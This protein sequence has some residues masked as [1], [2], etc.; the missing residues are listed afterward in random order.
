M[1]DTLESTIAELK[2]D[3]AILEDNENRRREFISNI[4]HE[5]KTPIALI[6]GYAEGLQEGVMDD[7]DSRNMYL[8]VIIDE[9][10]RMNRLVKELLTLNQLER[11]EDTVLE[12]VDLNGL[13]RGVID[14]NTILFETNDIEVTYPDLS[15][16]LI[17]LADEF[18][19]EQVV[20][21]YISNAIHYSKA[22]DS[23]NKKR[24]DIKQTIKDDIV[25][26]SVFN[27]GD[28]I[29]DK[30]IDQIWDKFYKVDKARSREYGGS[31][32]GLSVVKAVMEKFKHKYGVI[33]HADGVEF[34]FELEINKQ[35]I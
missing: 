2:K 23:D 14:A 15:N 19:L 16:E 22:E 25:R 35:R 1:S 4:S 11:E 28:N 26:V 10:Q 8:E 20:N 31:G 34:F 29:S 18:L 3:I 21:N 9:S 12:N 13:L 33:N 17:C 27:T 6:Q 5:L 30:D 32:I 24:I 7:E